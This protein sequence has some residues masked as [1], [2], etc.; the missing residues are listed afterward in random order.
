MATSLWR[1]SKKRYAATAFSGAGGIL[2]DGRWNRK[3][4]AIV[5]SAD[6]LALALLEILVH[7]E[8][9]TLGKLPLFVSFEASVEDHLVETIDPSSIPDDWQKWPQSSSTQNFGDD[10][11]RSMRSVVLKIPSTIVP[12]QSNFLINPA[13]PDFTQ[14]TI[15]KTEPFEIDQRLFS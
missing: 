5:Y 10:W 1:I 8:D 9:R 14:I 4:R 11:L 3:G 6:S 12:S 2:A 13:H 7:I 15:N